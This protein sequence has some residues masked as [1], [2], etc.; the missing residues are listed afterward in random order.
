MAPVCLRFG[1]GNSSL[2]DVRISL[3]HH[4]DAVDDGT[5]G[6]AQSASGAVLRHAS[7]VRLRRKLD[8]LIARIVTCHVTFT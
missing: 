3:G 4:L 8:R 1:V 2:D 6:D 5:N 7:Q